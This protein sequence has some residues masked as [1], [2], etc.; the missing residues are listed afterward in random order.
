MYTVLSLSTET[1]LYE[2][3]K[4]G[5]LTLIVLIYFTDTHTFIFLQAYLYGFMQECLLKHTAL[6]TA[7]II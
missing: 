3:E 6:S 5:Q 4:K 1:V 7:F 2:Y